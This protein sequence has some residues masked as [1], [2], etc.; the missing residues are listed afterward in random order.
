MPPR[1]QVEPYANQPGRETFSCGN[2]VLDRYLRELAGQQARRNI[3]SLVV[4]LDAG[5]GRISG[6][7]TLSSY[8]VS[9]ADLPSSS[10][11]GFP[12]VVPATLLGR[13]AVDRNFQGLGMGAAL[14]SHAVARAVS[15]S[16][17]VASAVI[18]VDAIDEDAAGFYAM[19]GF[20]SFR[21]QPLRLFIPVRSALAYA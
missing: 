12:R 11:R 10:Q 15:A 2:A 17:L 14:L 5:S 3:A 20:A 13:L 7:Y 21:E 16:E 8:A 9:S 4:A 18:V 19:Y 1:W 6:F